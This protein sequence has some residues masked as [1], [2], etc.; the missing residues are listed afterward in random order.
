MWRD[1][2][3]CTGAPTELFFPGRGENATRAKAICSTCPVKVECLADAARDW[4]D[5]GH[6]GGIRG[7]TTPKER[8]T[9]DR[10]AWMEVAS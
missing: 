4:D 10:R 2:A 3:A 5:W 6:L 1:R 7:G 8:R 9:M